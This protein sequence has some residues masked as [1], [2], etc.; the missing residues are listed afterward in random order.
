MIRSTLS[1]LAVGLATLLLAATAHAATPKATQKY[2]HEHVARLHRH[3]RLTP[4]QRAAR[5][6]RYHHEH[7]ARAHRHRAVLRAKH[8]HHG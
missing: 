8:Q 2:H 6:Q 1:K 3:A 5:R 4:A 7:L